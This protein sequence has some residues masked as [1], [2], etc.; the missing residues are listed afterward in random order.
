MKTLNIETHPFNDKIGIPSLNE[1]TNKLII[2]TFPAFQVTNEN[3]PRLNFYYGSTDNKFWDLIH[4]VLD[5]K[6]EITTENILDYLKKNNFGIIDIIRKCYR[7]DNTSSA[8]EDL[9]IIEFQD[10]IN[11]LTKFK[12]DTIYTTSKLVTSLFKKQI[13][14]LLD[15]TK[16]TV[17]GQR[18]MRR[19]EIYIKIKSGDFEFEK[20]QLPAHIF[21][22]Y[23]ELKII[24]LYSPSDQ[25][26]RGI[27]KGLNNKKIDIKPEEY[28][29]KQYEQFFKK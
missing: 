1:T 10:M 29:R 26:F 18:R 14:P 24:T 22:T 25:G 17:N 20:V 23:R 16:E 4:E 5:I 21:K 11:I 9:S 19:T 6:S 2:G 12:V 27:R 7:K 8:D 15:K 3:S 13:E 28:R